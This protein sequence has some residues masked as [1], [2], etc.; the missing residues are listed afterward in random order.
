[1]STIS[2]VDRVADP[3]TFRERW[4]G[5][6]GYE[7]ASSVFGT[8]STSFLLPV[9]VVTLAAQ[10][11][12]AQY[13]PGLEGVP[14]QCGQGTYTDC[15]IC[16]EGQGLTLKYQGGAVTIWQLKVPVLGTAW[17][18]KPDIYYFIVTCATGLVS[19]V[20]LFLFAPLGDTGTWRKG[21]LYA[22]TIIGSLATACC[23]FITDGDLFWVVGIL[24]IVA[25]VA[26]TT[27]RP[28]YNAYLPMLTDLD[29]AVDKAHI[30]DAPEYLQLRARV[31]VALSHHAIGWGSMGSAI[32]SGIGLGIYRVYNDNVSSNS[33]LRDVVNITMLVVGLWW[34]LFGVISITY[35]LSRGVQDRHDRLFIFYSWESMTLTLKT[36]CTQY[37]QAY[38]FLWLLLLYNGCV[39]SFAYIA[40]RTATINCVER[41][42]LVMV[43]MVAQI[44]RVLGTFV[45]LWVQRYTN[46]SD[47]AMISVHLI[48]FLFLAIWGSIG[49]F[50]S[51]TTSY[52]R[53]WEMFLLTAI[54]EFNNGSLQSYHRTVFASMIPRDSESRF[55]AWFILVQTASY[56]LATFIMA[57]ITSFTNNLQLCMLLSAAV[58]S[59]GLILVWNFLHPRRGMEQSGRRP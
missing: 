8:L 15:L 37:T 53:G 26:Y 35:M 38:T 2:F 58:L 12:W 54:A 16:T 59:V 30:N 18:V 7:F 44:S 17:M 13:V 48:V 28:L 11:S 33:P 27:G 32:V 4:L 50:V 31:Q 45:C 51:T 10:W 20:S 3:L 5:W 23:F 39:H 21:V 36:L 43:E 9:L 42:S 14:P 1:M 55:F 19:M 25:G 46:A 57:I 29:P 47:K 41:A 40:G 22:T 56:V 24:G 6:H 34:L 49:G 52:S